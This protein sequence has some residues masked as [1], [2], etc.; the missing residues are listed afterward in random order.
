LDELLALIGEGENAAFIR[1]LFAPY[2]LDTTAH[3]SGD[4]ISIEP[5]I[6]KGKKATMTK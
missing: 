4:K 2:P 1:N 3:Q 6:E 5:S